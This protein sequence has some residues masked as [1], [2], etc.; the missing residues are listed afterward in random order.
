MLKNKF[1]RR[2]VQAVV[3]AALFVS[4]SSYS[5]VL[6]TYTSRAAWAT[7]AASAL[8]TEDFADATLAPG[9]STANGS[10]GGVFSGTA[11]TQFNDGGNPRWN[12]APG[13][14]AVG[15]DF[16]FTPGGAGDGVIFAITFADNSLGS[17]FL[18]NPVG[19]IFQGFFGFVSD[20]AITAI[21][22][23]SPF[24]GVE[25]FNADD[26]QFAVAGGGTVPEPGTLALTG[27][28]LLSGLFARRR[29]PK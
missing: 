12:F 2:A 13:S 10:I 26:L 16:D 29:R 23:D 17:A 21:R 7:A 18:G 15:A 14:A 20:V 11:N 28:A 3:G 8:S 22:F 9:L 24:T 25:N 5:A 4:A 6:T 27:L 1:G 19:G